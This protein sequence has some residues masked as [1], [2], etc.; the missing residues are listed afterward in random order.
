M[1]DRLLTKKEAAELLGVSER[2]IDR[3]RAAGAKLGET[4]LGR[5][6]RFRAST[7]EKLA[8]KGLRV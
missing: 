6:I 1:A 7:I 3:W 2:T 5:I 4:K 8:E